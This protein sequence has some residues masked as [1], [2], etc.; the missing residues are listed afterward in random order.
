MAK[1][2]IDNIEE[3]ICLI[4]LAVMTVLTFTNVVTRSS[5]AMYSISP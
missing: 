1:K 5:R 2:I 3:I 4:A